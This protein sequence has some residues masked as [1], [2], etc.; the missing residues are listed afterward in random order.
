MTEEELR[1][2]IERLKQIADL[3]GDVLTDDGLTITTCGTNVALGHGVGFC[4][5]RFGSAAES[6]K[7]AQ[8]RAATSAFEHCLRRCDGL[9]CP[10]SSKC[11]FDWDANKGFTDR[12]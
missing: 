2:L 10:P 9:T 5:V 12:C 6:T 4:T 7:N 3:A 1:A 8:S 11:S